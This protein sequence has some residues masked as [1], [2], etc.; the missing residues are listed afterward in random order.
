MADGK[1]GDACPK[2]EE[3]QR[4]DP[5]PGTQFN[6]GDCYEHLG[7]NASAWAL[8]LNVAAA[9]KSAGLSDREKTA[10]ERAL[11]AEAKL[12]KLSVQAPNA[13]SGMEITRDGVVVGRPQ[14]GVPVPVDPGTHRIVASA[15]GKKPWERTVDISAE[16]IVV[17]VPGLA[18]AAASSSAPS[19]AAP[20]EPE[21][22]GRTQRMLAIVAA[23]VGVIGIGVGS[24]FGLKDK[25]KLDD[26]T[27]HCRGN[28]CD[29]EGVSLRSDAIAAGN[30]STAMFTVGI[31]ALA[32]GG[33]LWFTAKSADAPPAQTTALRVSPTFTTSGGGATLVGAW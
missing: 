33:V 11:A 18:D 26:S 28:A 5:A 13:P 20:H 8:F 19:D 16:S 9:A 6:L 4:L 29:A 22:P 15:P 24:A 32:G 14:W 12:V 1:Y 10:R 21:H 23:G 27:S 25:S 31:L 2:L 7:R 17:E 30:V 3:S